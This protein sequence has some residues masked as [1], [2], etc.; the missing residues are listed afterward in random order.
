MKLGFI[1]SALVATSSVAE[2]TPIWKR[3]TFRKDDSRA[4]ATSFVNATSIGYD[5]NY[6][7]TTGVATVTT[8]VA[9]AN[10][11]AVPNTLQGFN[12]TNATN[13]TIPIVSNG[14]ANYSNLTN[15]TFPAVPE[16]LQVV[17][18]GGIVPILNQTHLN[19]TVLFNT[20]L[21]LNATQLY[22]VSA[23]V[24]ELLT[25]D[26]KAVVITSSRRGLEGLGFFTAVVLDTTTPIVVT[27]D[28]ALGIL[29]ANSTSAA[30]RGALV[31]DR[32]GLIYSG[33]FGPS[34]APGAGIPIGIVN[35]QDEV[36]FY[37][38][39]SLPAFIGTDS[40][41]R[42]NYTMFTDAHAYQN[43]SSRILVPVVYDATYLASTVDSLA[44][45]L[46]GLVV[47]VSGPAT[48]STAVSIANN[49]MPVVYAKTVGPL[50]YVSTDAVP[51]GAIAGGYLTPVKAQ[52]LLYIANA[53]DVDYALLTSLF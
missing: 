8:T 3:L 48:N 18:T 39:A 13:I 1:L 43:V 15:F 53:N 17:V 35:D 50:S 24:D 37:N 52:V 21:P 33:I 16:E 27:D 19:Y 22:N 49:T 6:T 23:T 14:T 41:I 10:A 2:A 29:V 31:V 25:N 26:T 51:E 38:D 30:G 20:S 7:N 45:T 42:T 36:I 9:A 40:T 47:V 44:S 11:T 46:S 12:F 5:T 32:R 4:N 28:V 34:D